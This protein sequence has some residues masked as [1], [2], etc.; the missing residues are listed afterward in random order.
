[1][2][3]TVQQE[4]DRRYLALQTDRDRYKPLWRSTTKLCAPRHGRWLTTERN[5]GEYKHKDI[6]HEAGLFARRILSAGLMSG[7]TSPS[8]PWMELTIDDINRAQYQ[9]HKLW[10][11]TVRDRMLTIF[12]ASNIYT[13][14]FSIYNELGPIGTA[15]AV[16]DESYDTV[17]HMHPNTVGQYVLA[18]DEHGRVNALFREYEMTV[19]QIYG[20]FVTKHGTDVLPQNIINAYDNGNYDDAFPVR[21]A[22]RPRRDFEPGALN[23]RR[24]P[25][26]SVYWLPQGTNHKGERLL[27]D[28]GY[29]E[30][31]L[32]APR[33]DVV[34]N[35]VYGYGPGEDSLGSLRALQYME[36]DFHVA[37]AMA[38]RPPTA[39]PIGMKK[40]GGSLMPGGRVYVP[41]GY[42]EQI[43]PIY[44]T[45]PDIGS[46]N[47]ERQNV[48]ER[49][50]QAFYADVIT[51]ISSLRRQGGGA[52]PTATEIQEIV[53]EK[54]VMLGPVIERMQVELIEPIIDRTF[55]IMVRKGLVP[56]PPP[57]MQ[58]HKLK[59]NHIS[60]LAQAQRSVA[61]GA[62]QRSTQFMM[63]YANVIP[64]VVDNVNHDEV[65]REYMQMQGLPPSGIN[66]RDAVAAERQRREEQQRQQASIESASQ[67]AAAVKDVGAI[68]TRGGHSNV[69][70]DLAGL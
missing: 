29:E 5:D 49:I 13:G 17:I 6:L 60:T 1:M 56:P 12:R 40:G 41:D 21:H 44:N 24:F 35:D 23:G 33:W 46:F 43:Y 42:K 31:P 25:V 61:T 45:R 4:L 57:D 70:A 51:A 10:L 18:T 52:D 37:I 22:I 7:M 8:R 67:M 20:K 15:A 48:A 34:G 55:S 50:Y 16:L 9:P 39:V 30:T 38:A 27:D 66:P 59:V 14:L 32:V 3:D 63:A 54:L 64:E 28:T 69:V 58:G 47:G 68:E 62:I 11:R 65:L 26:Q 36:K 53:G 2:A 19:E